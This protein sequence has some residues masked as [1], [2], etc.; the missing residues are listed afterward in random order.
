MKYY[1]LTNVPVSG[2]ET[3]SALPNELADTLSHC[4][5]AG[6]AKNAVRL[7]ALMDNI[8]IRGFIA[9]GDR[10]PVTTSFMLGLVGELRGECVMFKFEG[11]ELHPV[12]S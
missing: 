4:L 1:N 10:T 2:V 11:G 9:D 5:N 3:I 7:S 12:K 6:V 8:S